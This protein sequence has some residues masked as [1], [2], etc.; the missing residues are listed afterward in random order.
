MCMLRPWMKR[1]AELRE[2]L[3]EACPIVLCGPGGPCPRVS[4]RFGVVSSFD[5]IMYSGGA[6]GGYP[7]GFTI[8]DV[9]S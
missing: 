4:R 3:I 9:G 8:V 2:L 6:S 7:A 5:V 1:S